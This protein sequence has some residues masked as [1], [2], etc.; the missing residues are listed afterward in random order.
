MTVTGRGDNPIYYTVSH[1]FDSF[2]ERWNIDSTRKTWPFQ[3][4]HFTFSNAMF[5]QMEKLTPQHEVVHT[6]WNWKKKQVLRPPKKNMELFCIFSKIFNSIFLKFFCG[7]LSS[8][9]FLVWTKWRKML[10]LLC[11]SYI[12]LFW[13]WVFPYRSLTYRRVLEMALLHLKGFIH[14]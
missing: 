10:N 4:Q 3:L 11:E 14:E 7:S 1:V 5:F 2:R 9:P 12:W 6:S 13:G 8:L